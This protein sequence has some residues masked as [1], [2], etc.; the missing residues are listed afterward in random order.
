V[1]TTSHCPAAF[2]EATDN[3]VTA[4]E[5]YRECSRNHACLARWIRNGME[6]AR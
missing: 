3:H 1:T 6:A 5:G 4:M 2:G